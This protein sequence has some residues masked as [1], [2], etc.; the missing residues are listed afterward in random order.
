MERRVL[1]T[2]SSGFIGQA[3][4]RALTAHGCQV[5]PFDLVTG[6]DV[7][8][9]DQLRG[10]L[11][12]V[13][14][15]VHLAAPSSIVHFAQNPTECRR[16]TVEGTANLLSL[17]E[18]RVIVPST[19]G[20]YAATAALAR[21][22]VSSLMPVNAYADAKLAVEELCATANAHGRDAKVLRIFTGYGPDEWRKG[23][24]ASPV[25]HVIAA[26]RSGERPEIFGDGRQR[27][28]CVYIDDIVAAIVRTLDVNTVETTFNVGTGCAVS[29]LE[30][31][32]EANRQLGTSF[33]PTFIKPRFPVAP[34][35]AADIARSA[36]ILGFRAVVTLAD[37]IRNTIRAYEAAPL[38]QAGRA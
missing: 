35:L 26:L 28:D 11:R 30:V 33:R 10:A 14:S 24:A 15:V 17:F 19:A 5:R 6:Q 38:M 31:V 34:L 3:V 18:G 16:T 7:L 22:G 25:M 12:N 8:N 21:E 32:D 20:V 29:L 13:Y 1:V 37:G 4:V 9:R 36:S 27:R 2:G 23:A